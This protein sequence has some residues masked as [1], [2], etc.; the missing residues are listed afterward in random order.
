MEL[1]LQGNTFYP[2]KEKKNTTKKLTPSH[3][4]IFGTPEK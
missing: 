4:T 3:A 2:T 1:D